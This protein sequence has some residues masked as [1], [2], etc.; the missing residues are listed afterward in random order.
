QEALDFL[1]KQTFDLVLMDLQMPVMG[2]LEATTAIR[3]REKET[4]KHLRIVAM[5]AHAMNGD[6]ERCIAA[7]MDGYLSKPVDPQ[8]LFAVVEQPAEEAETANAAPTNA[9]AGSAA[10]STSSTGSTATTSAG[11]AAGPQRVTP[12]AGPVTFDEEDLR[13]RVAGDEQLMADV[14]RLFMDDC[15]KRLAAIKD[16]IDAGDAAALKSAAHT[17]KG[18]AGNL[19]ASGVFE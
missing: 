17:L 11:A 13:A 1:A 6:R 7:G 19:S 3:E 10:S 2:G 9:A 18:A 15:P 8:M 12:A 14:V 5:T 16:A 4:G